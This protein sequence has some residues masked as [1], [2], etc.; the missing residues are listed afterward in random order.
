MQLFDID[1]KNL[2][3]L[4][5]KSR[6]GR[7]MFG[8]MLGWVLLLA[9]LNQEAQKYCHANICKKIIQALRAFPQSPIALHNPLQLLNLATVEQE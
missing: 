7:V 4:G 3:D 8:A 5:L 6:V 9:D 1:F 2:R